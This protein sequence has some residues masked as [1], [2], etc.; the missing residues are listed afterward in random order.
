M[1]KQH[2]AE[3]LRSGLVRSNS[4]VSRLCR[5]YAPGRAE[6]DSSGRFQELSKNWWE[7]LASR[8]DWRAAAELGEI[9]TVICPDQSFGWENWAWALHKQGQTKEA[10][11]IL[12][13]VLKKLKLPGPPSGRAAYC[14][15]CFCSV[16]GR[17]DEGARWLR[18]AEIRAVNKDAFRFHVLRE[19]DLQDFWASLPPG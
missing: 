19:P 17:K 14:L 8:Q 13:P 2:S 1:N 18:L 3:R 16:L 15:A 9:S 11:R 10:Y 4:M 7:T 5:N 12:A 6:N